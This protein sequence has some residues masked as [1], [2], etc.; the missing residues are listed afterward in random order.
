MD[1]Q[2]IKSKLVDNEELMSA[3]KDSHNSL[4]GD[5]TDI[6]QKVHDLNNQF[7][8]TVQFVKDKFKHHAQLAGKLS[9]FLFEVNSAKKEDFS[10]LDNELI[11]N[12]RE[13][14]SIEAQIQD[15]IN[16]EILEKL[17][18]SRS[19]IEEL[20]ESNT[21]LAKLIMKAQDKSRVL[22]FM[23]KKIQNPGNNTY[24]EIL[25]TSKEIE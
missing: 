17:S 22:F 15:E 4:G 21:N 6:Y 8:T 20:I 11:E 12:I 14:V 10:N 18:K 1:V 5:M 23:T 24:S 2:D 19:N 13:V 25:R 9:T 16:S 7:S 3:I